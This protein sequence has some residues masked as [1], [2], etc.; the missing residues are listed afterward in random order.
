MLE[1]YSAETKWSIVLL[2]SSSVPRKPDGGE[3]IVLIL[4]E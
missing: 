1:Y 3:S 4:V 2:D